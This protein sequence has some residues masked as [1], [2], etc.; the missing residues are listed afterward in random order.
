MP[1]QS[2]SSY[3]RPTGRVYPLKDA[4]F[5][6]PIKTTFRKYIQFCFLNQTWQFKAL[7]CSLSVTP[8][9]ITAIMSFVAKLCHEQGINIHYQWREDKHKEIHKVIQ[10]TPEID[11]IVQ[12]WTRPHLW[13]LSVTLAPLVA[14][15]HLLP[16]PVTRDGEPT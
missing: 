2:S 15:L 5:L 16:I 10:S 6:I 13:N 1:S 11:T 14:H 12:W 3:T 8:Q 4:Y 9:I 7:P